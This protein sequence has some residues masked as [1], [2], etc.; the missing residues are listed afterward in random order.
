MLGKQICTKGSIHNIYSAINRFLLMLHM[1]KHI[2][3]SPLNNAFKLRRDGRKIKRI[4]KNPQH[5]SLVALA[6]CWQA[7]GGLWLRNR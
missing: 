7:C 2:K 1:R 4:T 3:K 6:G 5:K